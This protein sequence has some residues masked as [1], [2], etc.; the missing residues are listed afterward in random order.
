M[1][2][3]KGKGN[4]EEGKKADCLRATHRHRRLRSS[5]FTLTEIL[6]VVAIFALAMLIATNIFLLVSQSQRR[7]TTQQKLQGDVRFALE[8]MARDIRFG[9]VDYGCYDGTTVCQ[10]GTTTHDLLTDTNGNATLL[11][12]IDANGNRKRYAMMTEPGTE[13][14][15]LYTCTIDA[16]A[17]EPVDRC[18]DSSGSLANWEIVTARGIHV[19]DIR[20]FIAPYVNPFA[21][22]AASCAGPYASDE[23]PRV[24]IVFRTIQDSAE[25]VPESVSQQ[26]TVV[27]RFYPR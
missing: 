11:A 15:K 16:G 12:L 7:A 3:H 2:M 14:K 20:F 26:T 24:T 27:T 9:T 13:L 4:R 23:Q 21:P 25:A 8:A 10:P 6:I 18:S 17:G 19:S 5:G 1:R 22:C